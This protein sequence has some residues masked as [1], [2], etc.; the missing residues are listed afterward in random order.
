MIIVENKQ[1]DN[2]P[3]LHLVKKENANDQLPFVIFIHGFT[4][5]K[6]HNLHYAYLLAEKG[7]RVVLP[8]AVYHGE[9]T[10]GLDEQALMKHFW[11]IVIRTIHEL[12]VIKQ[13]FENEAII[14][15]N[16]IGLAGTSMGGIVTLGALT[17]YDWI[18]TAVSL[19]GMPA[20]EKF[21]VWQLQELEKLQIK[22]SI[23]NKEVESI[24][25]KIREYDLSLQPEKLTK[26][27]IL[28]WHGQKDPVVPFSYTY[29]FYQEI[30]PLYQSNPE[31]IKFITDENGGHKV[32]RKGILN[33]ITW[34]EKHL[35]SSC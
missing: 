21:A 6:E 27:P 30:K 32:S 11:E 1:V 7:F 18:K 29:E 2:I 8:E 25:E 14:D 20:Y 33:T 3:L 31:R 16:K 4:S 10:E 9:R 5:A 35:S 12:S 28:F 26:R 22:M 24:L 17:Q 15:C 34:F 23:S 19:M 13:Q